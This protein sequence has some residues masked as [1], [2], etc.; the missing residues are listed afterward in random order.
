MQH[1]FS[2]IT[3][4]FNRIVD[5]GHTICSKCLY[6]GRVS[7]RLSVLLVNSGSDMQLVC[8]LP[9]IDWHLLLAIALEWAADIDNSCWLQSSGC[10]QRQW[11]S[12]LL[13]QED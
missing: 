12:E 3:V 13:S 5:D 8:C 4:L 11:H 2:C 6:N 7:I 1:E 9:A 10:S